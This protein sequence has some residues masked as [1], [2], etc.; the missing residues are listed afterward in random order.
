MSLLSFVSPSLQRPLFWYFSL[1]L[2]SPFPPSLLP[3]L[4]PLTFHPP[5]YISSFLFIPLPPC[6]SPPFFPP[7]RE[8]EASID[9]LSLCNAVFDG[10]GNFL[11][12]RCPFI[13]MMILRLLLS[14]LSS[15]DVFFCH[16]LLSYSFN[17]VNLLLSPYNLAHLYSLILSILPSPLLS[18]LVL[19][20][21]VLSCLVLSCLVFS[22][23]VLSCLISPYLFLHCLVLSCLV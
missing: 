9:T 22:C 1:P 23:L 3:P 17:P 14:S 18:C 4:T 7:S 20:C 15:S 16:V 8:L 11:V 6:L 21:L 13:A 10:S 19:S 5:S 12:S 2:T